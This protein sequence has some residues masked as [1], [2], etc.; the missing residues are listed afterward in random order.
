MDSVSVLDYIVDKN[1]VYNNIWCSQYLIIILLLPQQVPPIDQKRIVAFIN[2][3]VVNTVAFLNKFA[4]N[5]ETKFIDFDSKL[6]KVEAS[7]AIL[8]AK[9]DEIMCYH[10]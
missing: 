3:F 10:K 5:C 7:L 6:H 2:H 9:V 8:E 1:Q 4:V